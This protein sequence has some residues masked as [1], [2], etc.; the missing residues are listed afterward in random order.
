MLVTICPTPGRWPGGWPD[1]IEAGRRRDTR[2]LLH[3]QVKVVTLSVQ[4]AHPGVNCPGVSV[5]K[6]VG[7]CKFA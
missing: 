2:G 4:Q 7:F 6:S 5:G 1:E 3:C